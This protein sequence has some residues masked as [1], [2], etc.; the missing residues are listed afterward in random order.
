MIEVI[1]YFMSFV[2]MIGFLYMLYF[3]SNPPKDVK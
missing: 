2:M 3:L 1:L